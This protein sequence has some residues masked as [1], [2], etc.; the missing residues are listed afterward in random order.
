VRRGVEAAQALLP[1]LDSGLYKSD[2][3]TLQAQPG[4]LPQLLALVLGAGSK[5]RPAGYRNCLTSLNAAATTAGLPG[6]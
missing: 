4:S 5:P 6:I 2:F 3:A 1:C